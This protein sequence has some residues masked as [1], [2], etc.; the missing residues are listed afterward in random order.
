MRKP[1]VIDVAYYWLKGAR[2]LG[3]LDPRGDWDRLIDLLD[4]ARKCMDE[5]AAPT[6]SNQET[7]RDK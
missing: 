3:Y 2:S 4:S 6:A 1:N 5:S 7:E